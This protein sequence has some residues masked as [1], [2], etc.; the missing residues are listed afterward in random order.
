MIPRSISVLCDTCVI[1]E[2]FRTN[3]WKSLMERCTIVISEIIKNETKYYKDDSGNKRKIDLST[4]SNISCISRPYSDLL[5][6]M[7]DF[8]LF[9]VD[10]L[11]EGEAELLSYLY[12]NKDKSNIRICSGDAIVFK[13]LGRDLKLGGSER[14][15]SLEELLPENK[16]SSLRRQFKKIFKDEKI[17]EGLM[18]SNIN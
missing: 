6:F 3:S 5:K 10:K 4:Y 17:Q 15:V 16:K 13:I 7:S 1:I 12:S 18:E 11:D 9:N 14:C 2:A 8:N